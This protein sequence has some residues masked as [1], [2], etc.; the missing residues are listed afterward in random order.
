MIQEYTQ[1][2]TEMETNALIEVLCLACIAGMVFALA[3]VL[4]LYDLLDNI[5]KRKTRKSHERIN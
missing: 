1:G 5:S 2:L 3:V 4:W